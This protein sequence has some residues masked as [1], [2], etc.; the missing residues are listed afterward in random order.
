M[1]NVRRAVARRMSTSWQ[2]VPHVTQ[3]DRADVGELEA[4][5]RTLKRTSPELPLTVTAFAVAVC[6]AALREFPQFN[7]SLDVARDEIVY[8]RYVNIGVAV[9]TERGLIVP[10]IPEA[11]RKSLAALVHRDR[12]GGGGSAHHRAPA[13]AA[14][15]AGRSPSPT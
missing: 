5:R 13:R 9:D 10:V 12:R 1:R 4:V 3:H 7:A 15:R 8:K 11:D 14:S 6:A 2:T